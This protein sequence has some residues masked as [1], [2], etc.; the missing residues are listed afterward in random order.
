M[1]AYDF[2]VCVQKI[3]LGI[4][5]TPVAFHEC[6]IIPVGNETDVLAVPLLGVDKMLCFGNFPHLVLGKRT[7]GE[8]RVA[9]LLLGEGIEEIGLILGKIL[10]PE[11][12]IPSGIRVFLNFHIMTG[13]DVVTAQ[14]Y[15]LVQQQPEFEMPVAFHTGVG[16]AAGF[17]AGYKGFHDILPEFPGKRENVEGDTQS[18]GHS[19]SPPDIFFGM[20]VCAGD[21]V[22]QKHRSPYTV[23]PRLLHEICGYGA[24]HT[25]AHGDECF[26]VAHG[27]TSFL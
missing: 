7:Q 24:V 21:T 19:G 2:S 27:M 13:D 5:C 18:L 9:Q 14:L 10:C 17:I 3:S 16:G 4:G 1:L 23:E 8:Q 6:N 22:R 25:A 15:S 26:L 11:Q 20:A 12:K